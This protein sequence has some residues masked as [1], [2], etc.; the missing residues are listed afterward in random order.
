[1]R[2]VILF[3]F[4]LAKVHILLTFNSVDEQL[5]CR[6]HTAQWDSVAMP[7]S[8]MHSTHPY[9]IAVQSHCCTAAAA[10]AAAAQKHVWNCTNANMRCLHLLLLL[11]LLLTRPAVAPLRLPHWRP[12]PCCYVCCCC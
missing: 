3:R 1:M 2:L 4:G 8:Y 6:N 12:Y 10:L 7:M 5:H 11:V 9:P